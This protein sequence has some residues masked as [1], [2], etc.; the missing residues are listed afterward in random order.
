LPTSSPQPT[1]T[2][3]PTPRLLASPT[4][5]TP[6]QPVVID[7][8]P[9]EAFNILVLGIDRR[10]DQQKLPNTDVIMLVRVDPVEE[11]LVLLS[12]LRD[13]WVEIPGYG[14]SRINT[15]YRT[16][17]T[18]AP[19]SGLPLAR[20]TVSNLLD[21]PIDYTVLVDF[22]GFIGLIDQLGGITV[23]VEK[24]LY[25]PQYPTMDYG[26]QEVH[27]LPGPETMDGNRAL[28]YSRIRHPDSDFMR[29]RRQQAVVTAMAVRLRERGDLKNLMALDRITEAL[30]GYVWTD[31]P[32]EQMM[33]MAWAMRMYDATSVER[34]AMT[35]DMVST[36]VGNDQ[37]ALVPYQASLNYLAQLFMGTM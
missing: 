28:I 12:L 30:V 5:T 10:P 8:E 21:I 33:S 2:P 31:M 14:Y 22:Q 36:G 29:I 27:F 9:D 11:R 13:L 3:W 6:A 25:D 15:A 37:Y 18:Y 34:Y 17:E 1:L 24:E 7:T 20:Q 26:Y 16:G 32:R 19:G 35:V 23:Y 4:P